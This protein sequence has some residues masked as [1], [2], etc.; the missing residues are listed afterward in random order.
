VEITRAV[1]N[2]SSFDNVVFRVTW[3]AVVNVDVEGHC[4][5]AVTKGDKIS[6][7]PLKKMDA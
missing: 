5:L 4:V 6:I 2:H 7:S 3:A 1:E